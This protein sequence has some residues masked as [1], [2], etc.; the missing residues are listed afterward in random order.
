[1]RIYTHLRS[2]YIQTRGVGEQ[3]VQVQEG[4]GANG[5]PLGLYVTNK[6]CMPPSWFTGD[7]RPYKLKLCD[8][9]SI[10]VDVVS[11]VSSILY[12]QQ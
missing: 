12:P 7:D 10:S 9:K 4:G 2:K 1:M 5:A 6:W 11:N 3:M 8:H